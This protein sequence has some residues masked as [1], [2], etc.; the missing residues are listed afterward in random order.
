MLDKKIVEL[1]WQRDEKAISETD[2]K[3]GTYCRYIA[4]RILC[5]E[6]DTAEAVNDTYLK[7]WN[8]VPPNR[9]DPLKPYVG[10]ISRQTAINM[11]DK[12]HAQKREGGEYAVSIDELQECIPDNNSGADIGESVALKD[13]LNRFIASLPKRD[14]MVFVRRYWYVSSVAEIAKE[15]GLT[16]SNV[17][18]I[19]ARTRKKLKD[20][21]EKEGFDI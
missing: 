10:M 17:K 11:S 15:Y 7:T 1:Y 19:L 4:K 21:L 20:T 14:R 16:E 18:A 6:Q 9:P 12:K 2:K 3:Y 8:T 13:A 5:D